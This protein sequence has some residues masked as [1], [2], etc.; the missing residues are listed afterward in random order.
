MIYRAR[1]LNNERDRAVTRQL[2]SSDSQLDRLYKLLPAEI[3]GAYIGVRTLITP[4]RNDQDQFLLFFAILIL[5][6]APFFYHFILKITSIWQIAFLTFSYVVWAANIDIMRISAYGN[7]TDY[8][9]VIRFMLNSTFI[10]GLLVIWVL[11]LVPMVLQP[12]E[13]ISGRGTR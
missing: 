12:E 4:E 10:K 13:T 1:S 9:A 7:S 8:N 11:L 6:I 3:T 5:I 2:L